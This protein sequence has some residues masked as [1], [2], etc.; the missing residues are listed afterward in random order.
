MQKIIRIDNKIIVI[1]DNGCK[2][3]KENITDEEFDKIC[4][5]SDDELMMMFNPQYKEVKSIE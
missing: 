3:E 2:Y 5:L 1:L 4:N